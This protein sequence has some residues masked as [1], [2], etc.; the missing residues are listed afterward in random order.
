MFL[1]FAEK[2]FDLLKQSREEIFLL[3]ACRHIFARFDRTVACDN[4]YGN[5]R[6]PLPHFPG[7]FHA[8]HAF[9]AKVSDQDV[10]VLLI[11]FS[12]SFISVVSADRLITLHLQDLAA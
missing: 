8:V 11:E 12:Q 5:I 3:Q 1:R 2:E 10:E 7:Q 4:D 6:T 9:H